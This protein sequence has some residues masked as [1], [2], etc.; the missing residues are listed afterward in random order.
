MTTFQINKHIE[1]DEG[2]QGCNLTEF[3]IAAENTITDEQ[4]VDTFIHSKHFTYDSLRDSIKREPNKGYLG[5][6]FNIE[7]VG[8]HDFKKCDK[9]TTTK[10]L[11]DFLNEPNWG[12]DRDDFEKLLDKYFRFHELFKDREFYILSKNWFDI[13]DEKLLEPQSWCYTYYFIIIYLDRVVKQ[14]TLTEWTYD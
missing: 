13:K 14:L 4:L 2:F 12:S 9:T 11:I 5:Q 6:A 7:K 10:F 3:S 1:I 8:I